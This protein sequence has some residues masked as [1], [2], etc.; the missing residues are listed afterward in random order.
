MCD[1][2]LCGVEGD[3]LDIDGVS[4]IEGNRYD[5]RSED[6]LDTTDKRS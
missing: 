5:V 1:L 4:C 3:S 2:A 6:I